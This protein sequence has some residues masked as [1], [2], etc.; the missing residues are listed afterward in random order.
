MPIRTWIG[1]YRKWLELLIQ[2]KN[3]TKPI[4]D[5]TDHS[6]TEKVDFT[7]HWN[8]N[9]K[10]PNHST[11]KLVRSFGISNITLIDHK[12]FPKRYNTI[13]ETMEKYYEHMINHYIEI[14]EN[15]IKLDEEKVVDVTYRM[16]FIIHVLK[17]EI[18]IIKV[19]EEYIK[20]KMEEYK[21]PFEYYEKS[22]GKDFSL[23][24]VQKYKS[25]LDEAKARLDLIKSISPEEIWLEKLNVLKTELKKRF[26]KGVLSMKK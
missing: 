1:K 19:K 26:T 20:G 16:K 5:F 3:K 8:N 21:I 17:D 13:H 9:Y 22:R 6:T 4:F 7:V 14:K 10:Q 23:D 11:L 18:K 25:Q 2:S 12:G 15:R 24:S